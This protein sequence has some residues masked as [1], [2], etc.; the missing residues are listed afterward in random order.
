MSALGQKRTLPAS[1]DQLVGAREDRCWHSDAERLR[2][3]K[4]DDQ[5]DFSGLLDRQV[6]GF[7]AF[8]N[9]AA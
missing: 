9:S 5:L 4:L 6:G 8:E 2:G 1:F 7:L 3:L